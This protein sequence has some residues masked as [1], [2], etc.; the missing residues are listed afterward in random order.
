MYKY[1]E[2]NGKDVDTAVSSL[3]EA[4]DELHVDGNIISDS[5]A[6]CSR[7]FDVKG[8]VNTLGYYGIK[9]S[10]TTD[11]DTIYVTLN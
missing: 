4:Y 6:W 7:R 9:C 2:V 11:G 10:T 1:V 5:P 8:I 3:M